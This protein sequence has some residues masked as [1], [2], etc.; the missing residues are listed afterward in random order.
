[1]QGWLLL[2]TTFKMN[3]HLFLLFEIS[4]VTCSYCIFLGLWWNQV[5]RLWK[6]ACGHS[7]RVRPTMWRRW[8]R[9]SNW[10]KCPKAIRCIKFETNYAKKLNT[11]IKSK[12][13]ITS[14]LSMIASERRFPEYQ[15]HNHCPAACAYL[16]VWSRRSASLRRW[17]HAWVVSSNFYSF[18]CI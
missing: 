17:C 5:L 18:L 8:W 2:K 16:P 9:T 4:V 10:A 13:K 3:V 14:A 6:Q 1:M 7:S 11:G 12:F 15:L